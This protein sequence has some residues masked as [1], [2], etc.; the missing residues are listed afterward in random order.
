MHW[1]DW[2]LHDGHTRLSRQHW[3]W[4]GQV[5]PYG[6]AQLSH[7]VPIS[8]TKSRQ[9]LWRNSVAYTWCVFFLLSLH[10]L[11][12]TTLSA[13]NFL[14]DQ[15][16]TAKESIVSLAVD[17]DLQGNI[18]YSEV[19][20]NRQGIWVFPWWFLNTLSVILNCQG[21]CYFVECYS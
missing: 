17:I 16:Q 3:S 4:H 13:K 2:R 8:V 19:R 11:E 18:Y 6:L 1:H 9:K 12:E 21:N 10:S 14:E 15:N 20:V 7:A 5:T